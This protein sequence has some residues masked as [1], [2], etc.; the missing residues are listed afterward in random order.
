MFQQNS[1]PHSYFITYVHLHVAVWNSKIFLGG[2]IPAKFLKGCFCAKTPRLVSPLPDSIMTTMSRFLPGPVGL[3][4]FVGAIV[5]GTHS[6][7]REG[8]T[9]SHA[10]Q[11]RLYKEPTECLLCSH[12][13]KLY[14]RVVVCK[15][16]RLPGHIKPL[17]AWLNCVWRNKTLFFRQ[18]N[19]I[20][21]F[22]LDYINL[23]K[24]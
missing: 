6:E 16:K 4:S 24:R 8:I 22:P 2:W 14:H 15:G 18:N 3:R 10:Q 12:N 17:C 7:G 21:F 11:D 5:P 23:S 20:F 13:L 1:L 9:I 19:M